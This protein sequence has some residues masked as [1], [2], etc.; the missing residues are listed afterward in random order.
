MSFANNG[1]HHNSI[2][3]EA[4]NDHLCGL[5]GS[6]YINKLYMIVISFKFIH[7]WR[8]FT[9]LLNCSDMIAP[10][11]FRRQFF[12]HSVTPSHPTQEFPS[13]NLVWCQSFS[14][15]ANFLSALSF[16]PTDGVTV[17]S[18]ICEA[19]YFCIRARI[20]V[21]IA[22]FITMWLDYVA[23]FHCRRSVYDIE[24]G[25]PERLIEN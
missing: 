24:V 4:T 1:S 17:R 15:P 11:L 22:F 18:T 2:C 25:G 19:Q 5:H 8:H 23:R 7:F 10:L 12:T 20:N 13:D 6:S 9:Q 16:L 21:L 14:Q 3:W